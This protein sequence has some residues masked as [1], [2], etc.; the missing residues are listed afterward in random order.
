MTCWVKYF[1]A[2]ALVNSFC[3]AGLATRKPHA[4]FAALFHVKHYAVAEPDYRR[5]ARHF[6]DMAEGHALTQPS[7]LP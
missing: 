2:F 3:P 5:S 4:A 6:S 7:I 1:P